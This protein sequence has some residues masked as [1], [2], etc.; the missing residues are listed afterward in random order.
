MNKSPWFWPLSLLAGFIF[1]MFVSDVLS[2]SGVV[3]NFMFLA[4]VYFAMRFGPVSGQWM[5]FFWGLLADVSSISVFGSQTFMLTLVGY[6]V[7]RLQ[8]KIDEE[9]PAAQMG[10]VFLTF[11]LFLSGLV[12]FESLFGGSSQRFRIVDAGLQS[13]YCAVVA[14][15]FFALLGRWCRMVR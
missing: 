12:F 7:G 1:H 14:P 11:A 10:L 6:S 9:K 2:V 4:T 3:P 8:G 13:L 15:F 5:G